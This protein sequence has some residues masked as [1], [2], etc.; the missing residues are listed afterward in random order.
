[1]KKQLASKMQNQVSAKSL[2]QQERKKLF[3]IALSTFLVV[4]IVSEGIR[5]VLL[6][7]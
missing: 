1:M 4:V 3:A 2:K 6:N 5:L 7:G